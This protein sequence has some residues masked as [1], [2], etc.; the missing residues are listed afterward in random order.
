[1]AT[2][3]LPVCQRCNDESFNAAEIFILVGE[4]DI[5]YSNHTFIF[6]FFEVESRLLQPIKVSHRFHVHLVLKRHNNNNKLVITIEN[7]NIINNNNNKTVIK[8]K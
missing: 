1:M 6:V 8:I 3:R 2:G 7:N 4:A 5:R